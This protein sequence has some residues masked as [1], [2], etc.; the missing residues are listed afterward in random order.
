[1]LGEF[2]LTES[3]QNCHQLPYGCVLSELDLFYFGN[4]SPVGVIRFQP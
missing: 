2:F 1:M 3:I 4:K